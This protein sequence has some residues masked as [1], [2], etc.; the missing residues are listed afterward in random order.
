MPEH[1]FPLS[2]Q[3][4]VVRRIRTAIGGA[5]LA[6]LGCIIRSYPKTRSLAAVPSTAVF[7]AGSIPSLAPME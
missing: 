7:L 5:E 2:P 1:T 4:R 3:A 6:C